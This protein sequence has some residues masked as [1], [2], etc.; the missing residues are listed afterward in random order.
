MK[1]VLF[2]LLV[3]VTSSFAAEPF[4][5]QARLETL[6]ALRA[7]AVAEYRRAEALEE[8]A[9]AIKEAALLKDAQ[10]DAEE[11]RLK[12]DIEKSNVK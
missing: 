6:R 4:S 12:A 11:R 7:T 9:R 10:Y 2:L 5:P 1:T 8:A 3:L